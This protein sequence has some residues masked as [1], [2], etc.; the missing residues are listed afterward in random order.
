MSGGKLGFLS[1]SSDYVFAIDFGFAGFVITSL[2]PPPLP[3]PSNLGFS[4]PSE[5]GY[6]RSPDAVKI[7]LS[8]R[9]RRTVCSLPN[10]LYRPPLWIG[11]S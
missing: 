6:F 7:P 9:S 2:R 10:A 1:G 5:I 11:F 8:G 3:F 4:P